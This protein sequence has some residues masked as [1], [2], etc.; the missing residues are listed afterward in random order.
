MKNKQAQLIEQVV[1]EA[2]EEDQKAYEQVEVTLP[3]DFK[4]RILRL[5]EEPAAGKRYFTMRDRCIL[6]AAALLMLCC[7]TGMAAYPLISAAIGYDKVENESRDHDIYQTHYDTY[8]TDSHTKD[9]IGI[10]YTLSTVPEGYTEHSSIH[11]RGFS[12]TIWWRED[13]NGHAAITIVQGV[14]GGHWAIG[15][16]DCT[17]EKVIVQGYTGTWYHNERISCLF[18]ITENCVS[19][20]EI[21]GPDADTLDILSM[22]NTLVP[23]DMVQKDEAWN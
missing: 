18:W 8:T 21:I 2:F 15:T 5:A 20:M 6:L 11:Q 4:E 10:H 12:S 1:L 17:E 3:P 16:K 22:A 19:Y 23:V 9:S 7:L 13:S 14:P